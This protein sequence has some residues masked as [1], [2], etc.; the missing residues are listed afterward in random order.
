MHSLDLQTFKLYYYIVL[1]LINMTLFLSVTI[2]ICKTTRSV[3]ALTLLSFTPLLA[4]ALTYLAVETSFDHWLGLICACFVASVPIQS[5]LFAMQYLKSYLYT[6]V[7]A[8]SVVYKIHTFAK[9]FGV[10]FYVTLLIILR[11]KEQCAWKT[12]LT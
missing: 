8:K 9:Y 2:K 12:Y 6:C 7:G 10:L 3:F 1:A 11:W 5:W 4:I